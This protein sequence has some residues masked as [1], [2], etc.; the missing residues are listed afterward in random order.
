MPGGMSAWTR[1]AAVS[2]AVVF[3]SFGAYQIYDYD[4]PL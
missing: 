4:V 1:L 3:L 2:V